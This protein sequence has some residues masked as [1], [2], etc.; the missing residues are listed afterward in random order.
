MCM[1]YRTFC[2]CCQLFYMYY[3]DCVNTQTLNQHCS[4]PCFV[5]CIKL[6]YTCTKLCDYCKVKCK[7]KKHHPIFWFKRSFFIETMVVR[8]NYEL[9]RDPNIGSSS[10]IRVICRQKFSDANERQLAQKWQKK[11]ILWKLNQLAK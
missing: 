8:F 11:M 9:Q 2:R 3:P 4:K 10:S 6:C 1:V 5:F 7:D